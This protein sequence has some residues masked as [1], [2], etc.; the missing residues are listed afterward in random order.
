MRKIKTSRRTKK[1]IKS[2]L[3]SYKNQHVAQDVASNMLEKVMI[4][5]LGVASAITAIF[6]SLNILYRIPDFFRF[7]F[8]RLE[9]SK[10][11]DLG[12]SDADL[13]GFFSNFMMHGKSEFSLIAEY[14]G[15]QRE[16]FNDM[17]A[18]MMA[19]FRFLLDILLIVC[20]V[21]LILTVGIIV[22]F[23]FN[24]MSRQLRLSQNIGLIIYI[25]VM[26]GITV[27][28]NVY[29]GDAALSTVFT[30]VE[31]KHDDLLPQMFDER[32]T[33]ESTIAI[34]VISLIIL[35]LIRYA[36]WKL[37]EQKGIFSEGLKGIGK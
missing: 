33:L 22:I 4:V 25:V 34:C 23:Q 5:T 32:F 15:I 13:G 26:V 17:E 3:K 37:T 16:L 29:T 1:N 27:Y 24:K 7:E 30:G 18:G 8:D 20:I 21:S 14:Q 12:I 19:N 6:G 35:M 31:F 28:F 36:V 10:S 9:V 11:L 2:N